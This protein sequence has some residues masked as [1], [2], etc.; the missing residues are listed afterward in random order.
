MRSRQDVEI[1]G[2]DAERALSA[3]ASLHEAL[4]ESS[5]IP[6]ELIDCAVVGVPGVVEAA[7]GTLRLATNVPGLEGRAFGDDLRPA[8]DSSD[9]VYCARPAIRLV[10]AGNTRF[11]SLGYLALFSFSLAPAP[12]IS[13]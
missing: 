1:R 10:P 13:S 5:E 4:V 7:T 2:A 12:V 9:V 8:P 3:I 11:G 6:R